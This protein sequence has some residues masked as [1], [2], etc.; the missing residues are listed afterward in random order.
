MAQGA[1][2]SQ[3]GCHQPPHQGAI[4]IGKGLQAGM[5]AGA[6]KL[7]VKRAPLVQD[8]IKNIRCDPPRRKPGHLGWQCEPLSWHGTGTLRK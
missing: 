2:P 1:E 5:S 7:F 6:V 4:A 8:P 3:D